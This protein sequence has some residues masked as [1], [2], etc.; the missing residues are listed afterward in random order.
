MLN[1]F[2][3]T[4]I[5]LNLY[6][7][8]K[9]DLKKWDLLISHIKDKKINLI[10]TDQVIN[11]FNRNRENK[12]SSTLNMIQNY[13]PILSQPVLC[14]EMPEMQEIQSLISIIIDK[15]KL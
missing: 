10:I 14:Q 2:I 3:D 13:K 4:N 6:A 1:L 7:F 12:L 5:F 8:S 11:E 9:D 15:Q